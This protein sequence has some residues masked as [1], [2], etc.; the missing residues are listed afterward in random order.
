LCLLVT[1]AGPLLANIATRA[2]ALS[3]VTDAFIVVTL[4]GIVFFHLLPQGLAIGGLASLT[5]GLLGLAAPPLL[6]RIVFSK[7]AQA[8]HRGVLLLGLLG[9][10]LHAFSDGAALVISESL[11]LEHAHGGTDH[12][13]I[14]SHHDEHSTSLILGVLLH[15]LP[16]ALGV[17]WMGSRWG[18]ALSGW[19]SLFGLATAT[20]L[21]FL[22]GG[23]VIQHLDA[24]GVAVFQTFIAGS[25]LHVVIESHSPLKLGHSSHQH[26]ERCVAEEENMAK[27]LHRHTHSSHSHN[28]Q[29]AEDQLHS[30][31]GVFLAAVVLYVIS[32]THTPLASQESLST[33]DTLSTLLFESAP[34]LLL[35]YIGAGLLTSFFGDTAR[36]WLGGRYTLTQAARGV[37]F[38][39]PMPVCSCG[40]LPLYETLV[41]KGV[42]ASAAIAFLIATPEL[43]LDAILI[44]LPLL[45]T[46]LTIARVAAATIAA[47]TVSV[48]VARFM[49]IPQS[50]HVE[51]RVSHKSSKV[52]L[53]EGLK[54]GLIDLVDHTG[55]WVLVGLLVAAIIE[56]AVDY[57]RL[58]NLSAYLDVP[59]F[60]LLGIPIYVCASGATPLAAVL[61]HKG[62]SPGAAIA[63]L[64]TGPATNL[65]TFGVLSRLHS[66][67]SAWLFGLTMTLISIGI[68]YSTNTVFGTRLEHPLHDLASHAPNMIQTTS[69]ILLSALFTYSIWR[70]GPRAVLGEVFSQAH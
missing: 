6:E 44:S 34:A 11:S 53:Q 40:V 41:R 55:P 32:H 28:P 49:S 25:L 26:G 17:Y 21:G 36:R 65:T 47:L 51:E 46:D 12:S 20:T 27:D 5:S 22:V 10:L 19:V 2:P 43:G 13:D 67:K 14:D 56:P 52:R 45:G 35:A 54:F 38:G 15:R 60:A 18:G 59:I 63:F 1:F 69:L 4:S 50:T 66:A 31:I 3:T 9:L 39:L 7:N 64:L 61:I 16:V 37:A 70:R 48:I 8:A 30:F 42:P 29:P 23:P 24:V 57:E 68:G 33:Y 62:V 58:S